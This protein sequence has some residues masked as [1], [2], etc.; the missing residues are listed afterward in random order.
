MVGN[1]IHLHSITNEKG[2]GMGNE[3]FSDWKSCFGCRINKM[4]QIL[5]E[6]YKDSVSPYVMEV[7]DKSIEAFD[8]IFAEPIE[9]SSL[10]HSDY[11]LWNILVDEKSAKITAIIDPIDAGWADKEID[12]FHLE[13]ADGDRFELLKRYKRNSNI[14]ELFPVKNAFYWF[15]DDIKHMENMGWYEEER[16]TSFGNRLTSLME[17]Y[18]Y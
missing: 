5:H 16:F 13:N 15:W 6:D 3:M 18:I 12:L 14:S 17:E 1:L 4:H 8:K 7:A 11:N 2:F 9:K 10:I